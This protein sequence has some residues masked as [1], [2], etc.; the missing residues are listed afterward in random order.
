MSLNTLTPPITVE[1]VADIIKRWS[2]TEWQ[3]LLELVPALG[4]I[5]Q[6]KN[7][8]A[9]NGSAPHAIPPRRVRTVE[10]AEASVEALR[11]EILADPNHKPIPRDTPFLGGFTLGEY[12]AL[13]E[14]EQDQ[15]WNEAEAEFDWDELEEVEV[16]PDVLL[17]RCSLKKSPFKM[18]T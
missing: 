12:F 15:I 10:E 3:R 5:A 17:A 11:A 18:S 8:V 1:E 16:S 14:D 2:Q 4:E 6:S 9:Q 13:P 7:K